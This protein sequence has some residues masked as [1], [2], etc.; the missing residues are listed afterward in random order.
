MVERKKGKN[1]AHFSRIINGYIAH[2]AALL[3]INEF[4]VR[5]SHVFDRAIQ[6]VDT[7]FSCNFSRWCYSLT[8]AH[9]EWRF[10][11]P[12]RERE[13]KHHHKWKTVCE[14]QGERKAHI[15]NL[16]TWERKMSDKESTNTEEKWYFERKTRHFERE[17]SCLKCLQYFLLESNEQKHC[18]IY[19]FMIVVLLVYQTNF[20]CSWINTSYGTKCDVEQFG[21]YLFENGRENWNAHSLKMLKNS[22]LRFI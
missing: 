9:F 4:A 20:E 22:P 15:F 3:I 5:F 10:S 14:N 21:W 18:S 17:S 13:K 8:H 19:Y 6:T 12:E 7:F 11:S 1:S 16:R 2:N